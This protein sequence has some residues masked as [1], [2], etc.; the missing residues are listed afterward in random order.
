MNTEQENLPLNPPSLATINDAHSAEGRKIRL[1]ENKA[2]TED[3]L[4]RVDDSDFRELFDLGILAE[5]LGLLKLVNG[6][7]F[8]TIQGCHKIEKE[9]LARLEEASER[10]DSEKTVD[11]SNAYANITKSKAATFK[12]IGGL[13]GAQK[14]ERRGRKSFPKGAPIGPF[15][16]VKA[17]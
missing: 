8:A 16:D 14:E 6:A 15:V 10:G 4:I 3:G 1:A 11:I 9:L 13:Q 12:S 17:A 7:I 2:L 5:N